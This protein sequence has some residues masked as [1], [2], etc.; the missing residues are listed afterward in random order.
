MS[1]ILI[2]VAGALGAYAAYA[3]LSERTK[4]REQ[5][6]LSTHPR[7]SGYPPDLFTT[8]VSPS[9]AVWDTNTYEFTYATAEPKGCAL[10]GRM[11]KDI[12]SGY[13][14]APTTFAN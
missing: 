1:A 2:P 5:E 4:L 7:D 12:L 9:D 8:Y 14:R 13:G 6:S 10:D 3:V 11:R